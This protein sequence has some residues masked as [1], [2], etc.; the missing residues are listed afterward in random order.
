MLT[1]PSGRELAEY[2]KGRAQ[3]DLGRVW[4][5]VAE[6]GTQTSLEA[7]DAALRLRRAVDAALSSGVFR[8][9][10]AGT[11]FTGTSGSEGQSVEDDRHST[12]DYTEEERCRD[13]ELHGHTCDSHLDNDSRRAMSEIRS[14]K[15]AIRAHWKR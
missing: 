6:P 7:R 3:L 15:A 9:N 13:I 14:M 4:A 5:G 1:V 10:A 11:A 12:D 2:L 8:T